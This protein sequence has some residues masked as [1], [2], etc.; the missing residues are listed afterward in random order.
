MFF[1]YDSR[2]RM[3]ATNSDIR[4]EH[5]QVGPKSPPL[6]G[7]M[8]FLDPFTCDSPRDGGKVSRYTGLQNN[9]NTALHWLAY[10]QQIF[11]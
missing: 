4:P 10:F 9:W 7:T 8:S 3:K 1:K 5:P 2:D 6:S 11:P